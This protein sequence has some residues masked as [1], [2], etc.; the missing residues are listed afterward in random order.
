M[1]VNNKYNVYKRHQWCDT[2]VWI[3]P[4]CVY[5]H[6]FTKQQRTLCIILKKEHCM[7]IA[8]VAC[9]QR[10]DGVKSIQC[11]IG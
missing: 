1:K 5:V 7:T 3:M 4:F 10:T 9:I 8:E 11:H 6:V 2:G